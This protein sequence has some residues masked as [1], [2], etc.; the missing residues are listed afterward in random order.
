L[1]THVNPANMRL[2]KGGFAVAVVDSVVKRKTFAYEIDFTD[3]AQLTGVF[4]F[5][6]YGG[7]RLG[8]ASYGQLSTFNFD[9]VTIGIEK[10]GDSDFNRNWMVTNGSIIANTGDRLQDV[11]PVVVRGQGHLALTAVEAFSGGNGAL[12]TLGKSQDFMRIE[13]DKPLTVSMSGCRMRN[14][15]SPEPITV[16]NPKAKLR[17]VACYDCSDNLFEKTLP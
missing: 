11:H 13:G 14:Y 17:A 10:N 8:P 2:F 9:C 5:G 15:E 6:T 4:T 1:N 3:N 12:T 16:L 7:I